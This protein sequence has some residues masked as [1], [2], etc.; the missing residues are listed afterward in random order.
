MGTG[1]NI[2]P[3]ISLVG[4]SVDRSIDIDRVGKELREYGGNKVV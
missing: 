4:W 2:D 3:E 1:S